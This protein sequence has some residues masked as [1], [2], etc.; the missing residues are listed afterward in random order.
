MDNMN[1]TIQLGKIN[2]LHIERDTDFGFFLIPSD[3]KEEIISRSDTEEYEVLLPNAYITDDMQI[4]DKIDVFIYR[5]SEDRIVAT[6]QYPNAFVDQF[7]F[8]K[9]VDVAH[10]GAFVDIGLSKD[11]LVPRNRQKNAFEKGDYRIVRIVEDEQTNRLIGVEKITSFLNN[12]TQYLKQNDAVEV[13]VIAYTPLGYKVV[14]DHKHEGMIFKNECFTKLSI[15]DTTQAYIKNIRKDGKLDISL[16][17]IG[18]KNN[19]L[20]RDIVL[21]K[22][23]QNNGFLPYN[24]K[25]DPKDLQ[26]EFAMSKKNFKKSLTNLK[27]K[28]LINI[29]DKGI[30]LV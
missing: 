10:F 19:E 8:A 5:D 29:T 17:L 13:M 1:K 24:Y 20:T 27:D 15:G 25:S 6:T 28:N 7:V 21:D 22:L 23:K 9:V 18:E 14:V 12:N 26:N 30:T 11:L 3:S 16:Q 4:G 2:T